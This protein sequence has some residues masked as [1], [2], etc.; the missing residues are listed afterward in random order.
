MVM[1][2]AE[3][4]YAELGLTPGA[5]ENEVKR[6][7]RRLASHWHPDRNPSAEAS[8]RMQRINLALAQIR[9]AGPAADLEPPAAKPARPAEPPRRPEAADPRARP[10]AQADHDDRRDADASAGADADDEAGTQ[11][12]PDAEAEAAAPAA[13]ASYPEADIA[14]VDAE[15]DDAAYNAGQP[16]Q[17]CIR[18]TLEEAAAGCVRTLR[19]RVMAHC[20]AC[21]GIG[22]QVLKLACE[23]CDGRG[24]LRQSAWFGWYSLPPTPCSHC[25]GDGLA[26]RP[27]AVC[28]GI[29]HSAPHDYQIHVRLPHGVRHGD[30]LQL[31][32]RRRPGAADDAL[33]PVE[34]HLQVELLAH[35]L[36]ELDPADGSLSCEMPIDGFLWIAQRCVE[37][38]TL[39]AGLQPLLLT[40]ERLVY[41]LPGLGFPVERRGRDGARGA[42]RVSLLPQFPDTLSTDQN[43]LLDQLIATTSG[44][45]SPPPVPG[46]RLGDWAAAMHAWQAGNSTERAQA[47]D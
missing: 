29:G 7:W 31:S 10:G 23:P 13:P 1:M 30:E 4:A 17:R 40:R 47:P 9:S 43:I 35:P 2:S 28:A 8:Q 32:E 21:G 44:P 14:P 5:S 3:Q 38:P 45:A 22:Q 34:I 16:L 12:E 39:D 25:G 37:V 41:S 6:A 24:S 26:R 11:A 18:L 46:T 33:A 36:F 42:L 27:C 20:S 15:A 19:G